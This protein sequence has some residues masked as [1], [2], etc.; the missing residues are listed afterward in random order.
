MSAI[1]HGVIPAAGIGSRMGS[2]CPKQYL[3]INGSTLLELSVHALLTVPGMRSVTVALHPEDDRA[4]SLPLLR[5]G[6]LAG[7]SPRYIARTSSTRRP[8]AFQPSRYIFLPAAQSF[9]LRS[10]KSAMF[11][12]IVLPVTVMHSP[13]MVEGLSASS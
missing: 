11:F 12:A 7:L 2:E 10:E 5:Q 3:C 1:L 4:L 6:S 8:V 13:W 9:L